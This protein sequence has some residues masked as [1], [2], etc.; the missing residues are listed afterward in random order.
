MASIEKK[1]VTLVNAVPFNHRG[2]KHLA[3]LFS[4]KEMIQ[5]QTNIRRGSHAEENVMKT[6][7]EWHFKKKLRLY[8][9]KV[10]GMHRM[11]RP[12]W[13]CS[14]QL[15]KV[16]G[17]RVFYTNN[18]GMWVEDIHLDSQHMSM[19]DFYNTNNSHNRILHN[20]PKAILQNNS[21]NRILHTPK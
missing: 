8:V 12:C 21:H 14:K 16:P 9:T 20:P 13:F 15:K 18:D 7:K 4:G 5:M 3:I 1:V 17:L 6:Y 11:S 19:R 10:G 2:P